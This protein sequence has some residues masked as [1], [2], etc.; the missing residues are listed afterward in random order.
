MLRKQKQEKETQEITG[1]RKRGKNDSGNSV[2]SVI[3]RRKSTQ[4]E[5]TSEN[6]RLQHVTEHV[7]RPSLWLTIQVRGRK[8][9]VLPVLPTSRISPHS[10]FVIWFSL[11]IALRGR[12]IGVSIADIKV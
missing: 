4:P 7:P 10:N 6:I 11:R 3:V 12:Q 9:F 5:M 1:H 2:H 8:S